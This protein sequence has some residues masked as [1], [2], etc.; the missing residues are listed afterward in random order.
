[1]A[2][3]VG[4]VDPLDIAYATDVDRFDFAMEVTRDADGLR[5][6]RVDA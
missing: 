5:L 4:H 1:L 2:L 3:G 6:D